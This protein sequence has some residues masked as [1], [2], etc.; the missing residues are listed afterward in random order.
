MTPH[1]W[2][3]VKEIYTAAT[4]LPASEREAFVNEVAGTAPRVRDEALRLLRLDEGAEKRLAPLRVPEQFLEFAGERRT[5]FPGVRL[6]GRY[7]IIRFLA[8]GGMGEVYE[9][10]DLERGER[11]AIK[12][13]RAEMATE[14]H[15]AWLRREVEAARRIQHPNVCRVFDLVES[16]QAAF[17]TM[18]L[19]P[20]ETLAAYLRREGSLTERQAMP[21]I[22]QMVAGLSAAHAA[23]VVHRDFKPGNVMLVPRPDGPPRLVIMDFGVARQTPAE[24]NSTVFA[25]TSM[26]GAGTPSYMAPEQIEGKRSAEPADIYA[27]GVVMFEM[28]T[29]E[30]PYPADSLLSMAVQ[31]TREEPRSARLYAPSL[32]PTWEKA[33][34][35]CLEAQPGKRFASVRDVLGAL[36]TRSARA[37]QWKLVKRNLARWTR[38]KGLVFAGATAL[39]CCLAVLAWRNWPVSPDPPQ[40]L[41]WERSIMSLQAGEPL[42]AI[43]LLESDPA[44]QRRWPVRWHVDLALSW[45]ELGFSERARAQLNAAGRLFVPRADRLY[46]RAAQARLAGDRREAARLLAERAAEHPHD[47]MLLADLAW[48]ERGPVE[49]WKRVAELRPEHAAAHFYLAQAAAGAGAWREAESEFQKARLY[50]LTQNN[51]Q[52]VAAIAGRRGLQRIQSGEFEAAREDL[53]GT[54]SP[55]PAAGAGPCQHYTVVTAGIPD[56]FAGSAEPVSIIS[57]RYRSMQVSFQRPP[58]P[59]RGFDDPAAN[60]ELF[61]SLPLPPVRICSG[62]VELKIRRDSRAIEVLN[63]YLLMGVAPLN[64]QGYPVVRIPMWPTL[65]A[66]ERVVVFDLQAELFAD[67]MRAYANDAVSYLDV[68]AGDDTALDYFKLTVFY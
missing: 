46:I 52:L 65:T 59:Q 10:D 60:D 3:R 35:R 40:L 19:L 67:A 41:A 25:A 42:T 45:H 21:W 1:T 11:I 7:E 12:V 13:L 17:L 44:A 62:K 6:A 54:A 43:R 22:R 68:Y 58:Q 36:D 5:F 20:G 39:A 34:R 57:P 66:T 63:D 15:V 38:Q 48:L 2:Q 50:F 4:E 61:F 18:E 23:G 33:I 30:L 49:R 14:Q 29:G 55:V 47:A 56:N 64:G 32:R 8:R 28:L 53:A 37:W 26:A 51:P 24:R 9:A 27:L 31:K 16:G